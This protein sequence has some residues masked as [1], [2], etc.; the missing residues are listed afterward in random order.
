M[1]LRLPDQWVW[2]FWIAQ[3]GPDYHLFY[4]QAPRALGTTSARRTPRV[5]RPAVSGAH[6]LVADQP[7]GPFHYLTDKFL[8]GSPI[9]RYYA[10]KLVKGPDGEWQFM[11]WIASTPAGFFAGEIS[12]PLPVS[13]DSAGQLAPAE[14]RA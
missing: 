4:L 8:T 2:E 1:T 10:G 5:G 11:A 12:D 9:T 3:D 13:I 14:F 7:L 6:Y